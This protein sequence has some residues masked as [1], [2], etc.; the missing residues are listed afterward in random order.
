MKAEEIWSMRRKT[1][2]PVLAVLLAVLALLFACNA[3]KK[4]DAAV[5]QMQ[6]EE[7]VTAVFTDSGRSLIAE[8]QPFDKTKLYWKYAARK[9]LAADGQSMLDGSGL[10][11]GETVSY[12]EAGAEFVKEDRSEGLDNVPGFSQG[13]WDFMLFGYVRSG[14]EGSYTYSLVYSGEA[15]T[16]QLKKDGANSVSITVSPVSDH[17]PGTIKVDFANIVFDPIQ[18][19]TEGIAELTKSATYRPLTSEESTAVPSDGIVEVNPGLYVVQ[20]LFTFVINDETYT[21]ADGSVVTTV[22]S[23]QQTRVYGDLNELATSA[24]IVVNG[25]VYP[26]PMGT[27]SKE[28]DEESGKWTITF[29]NSNPDS[30]PTTFVW[31][32]DDDLQEGET[33]STFVYAP[34]YESVNITCVFGNSSGTGSASVYIK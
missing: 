24:N 17:G 32:V 12:N 20:V 4:A 8:L 33:E 11:S 1:I 26:N 23:N 15:K 10:R 5:T 25:A 19:E 27:V 7:L 22:Y 29:T 2:I 6:Q 13:L 18:L 30:V 31:Y 34:G 9:S 21:Y 3:D 14:E 16:V 28:W